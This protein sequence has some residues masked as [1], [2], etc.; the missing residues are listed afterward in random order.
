[1]FMYERWYVSVWGSGPSERGRG[2]YTPGTW[3]FTWKTREERDGWRTGV[4]VRTWNGGDGE[5][6]CGGGR[7]ERCRGGRGG[8]RE[9]KPHLI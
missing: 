5:W 9:V 1:M 8:G 6:A 3:R 7:E 2:I 4:R